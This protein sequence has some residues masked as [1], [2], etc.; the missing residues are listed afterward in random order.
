[1]KRTRPITGLIALPLL[2]LALVRPPQGRAAERPPVRHISG[3]PI[4]NF[5][6]MV[7]GCIYRSGQPSEQ[8]F[9]WLKQQGFRSVVCLRR[10]QDDDDATME[11]MGFHY[12][13]L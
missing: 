5:R 11:Q 9:R 10:E 7:P 3:A 13:Y 4:R 6:E 2:C 8:G 1:M 12:L